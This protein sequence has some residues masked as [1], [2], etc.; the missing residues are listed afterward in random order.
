MAGI[1]DTIAALETKLKQAKAKR[2]QLEQR[3]V[4]AL[5]KGKR[6]DDTR[7]KI[8]VGALVLDMME[9]DADT[10]TKMLGRLDKYLT[11]ADDRELFGLS[12]KPADDPQQAAS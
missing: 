2:E 4:H 11:R 12:A 9:R 7:R 10:K 3:K 6:A 5:I 1:D 8:L